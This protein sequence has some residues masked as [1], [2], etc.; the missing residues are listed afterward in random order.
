MKRLFTKAL[1]VLTSLIFALVLCE[2][3]LWLL[4]IEYPDF[5]EYDPILGSK[6]RPGIRGYYLKEGGGYVSI[7]SDGLRDREHSLHPPPNTLRIAVLGDSFAE[8][9][10]VDQE[11]AF[12]AVM[13]RNLRDCG[14][15]HGRQLE[16]I[17]FGQ[18]GF[19][20]TQE[21][22]AL[23]HRVW[24]YSPEVV[25][26]AFFTGNDVA[27]NSPA[28]MQ[29]EYNPYFSYQDNKLV[30]NDRRTRERWSE[31]QKKKS[32]GGSFKQW[33]EDH[34]RIFQLWRE[35]RKA[36][37][38]WW[39]QAR[40]NGRV[41]A[42]PSGSEP[43]LTDSIY[44]EPATAV[45]QEAWRVTEAVLLLMRDEIASKGA[46]FFVVVLTNGPQVHP[47]PAVRAEFA[48]SLGVTD[49]F[50]PDH[51]LAKFGE[52]EGIPVLLLAPAFQEQATRHNIF[53]HGFRDNLG[54]GHWNQDGHRLAGT[55]LA[56]WLCGHLN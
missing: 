37:K 28:F 43:G 46:K 24:K 21:L 33:R 54:G 17:N 11:E 47:D 29:F 18:A 20:T 53:F 13:A 2:A 5:F 36:L 23:R 14:D 22:L 7:N 38:T 30:L 32:W 51:R 35:G 49:L 34:F 4:G 42:A 10:Q 16:V 6:L 48:K 8:A 31:E 9:M 56:K 41:E 55:M 52:R 39:S 15:L 25:L 19:G 12:W 44:R 1:F 40:P 3:G 50:Y 45:W 27:D 26:L